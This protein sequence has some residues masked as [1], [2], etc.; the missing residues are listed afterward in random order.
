[1]VRQMQVNLVHHGLRRL[2]AYAAEPFDVAR[3]S[4]SLPPDTEDVG[5]VAVRAQRFGSTP[6]PADG[7][8]RRG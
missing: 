3:V 6:G 7:R 2:P 1:M 5:H 8:K 4:T